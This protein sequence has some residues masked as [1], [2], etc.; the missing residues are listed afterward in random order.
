MIACSLIAA[1]ITLSS[2]PLHAQVPD[3]TPFRAGQWGAEFTVSGNALGILRF[4]SPTTAWIGQVQ[5]SLESTDTD[6][7]SPPPEPGFPFSPAVQTFDAREIEARF[8]KRW[9][10]PLVADVLQHFTFGALASTDRQEQQVDENP[11]R[12][13]ATNSV[14]LFADFGAQWMV[15]KNLSLGAQFGLSA[16]V[17]RSNVEEGSNEL[18][19][20]NTAFALGPVGIRAALYF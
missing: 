1:A 17:A 15:T 4:A 2:A 3:S 12:V 9:Y 20:T 6:N 18:T 11:S 16:G 8:G 14:G 10:R 13:Q 5:V 7:D 19:V